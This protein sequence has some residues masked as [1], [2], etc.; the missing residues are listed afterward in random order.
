MLTDSSDELLLGDEASLVII[1]LFEQTLSPVP[2]FL[3]EEQE[4][5]EVDLA[6]DRALWEVLIHEVQDINLI[7]A[8]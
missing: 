6:L 5:V 8:D 7:I 2:I 4:V 1:E 3:E